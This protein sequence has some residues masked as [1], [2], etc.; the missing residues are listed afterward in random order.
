[1]G[2]PKVYEVGGCVRDE[3]L[4]KEPKDVDLMVCHITAEELLAE[5]QK[6]GKAE[7]LT[8]GDQLV[9]VRLVADFTGPEGVELALARTEISTGEGHKDFS[10]EPIPLPDKL[11]GKS[12]QERGQDPE[13]VQQVLIDLER[14]DFTCNAV[15]RDLDTV[16]PIDPL[17][18]KEDIEQRILRVVSPNSFRDDPLRILRGLGRISKD[19]LDP[20]PQTDMLARQ[21][22]QSISVD[23]EQ[24]GALSGERIQAELDKILSGADSAKALTLAIEW[25]VL[26]KVLPEFEACVGFDQQ[27]KYHS[28]TVDR[29]TMKA[30]QQADLMR[31][32][33]EEKLALLLHDIGK[34]GTAKPGKKGG[35][36]YYAADQSDPIW[37]TDQQRAKSHQ[38]RGA[39]IAEQALTRMAYPK[40]TIQQVKEMVEGHMFE[41]ERGFL[42]RPLARQQL[43]A[44]KM[45][46]RHGIETSR[47]LVRIRI[48][49]LAGK[50]KTSKDFDKDAKAL[51]EC[52]ES[53][54]S[55]PT[56]ISQLAFDG[57]QLQNLGMKPGPQIG[58]ALNKLLVIVVGDPAQNSP[59]RLL[60]HAQRLVA[61]SAD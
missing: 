47:S 35:L 16:Q 60:S 39:E 14:R 15:A 7:Q 9:G 55:N 2:L 45:I 40:K 53:Q 17:G 56:S 58:Q 20:C 24:K 42:E 38:Q 30:L 26:Q 5:C 52:L 18:G 59:Q 12:F 10:I 21:W 50:A 34:P 48:C 54:K 37:Q 11:R 3:L 51:L 41:A 36:M 22:A 8:V 1:M 57:R 4:G 13:I 61:A 46:A 43:L 19:Q 32:S 49:D 28:L 6:V 31:L 44:R 29:H 25:G 33:K 23:P 27:S